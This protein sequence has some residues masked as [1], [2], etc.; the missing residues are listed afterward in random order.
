MGDKKVA[1]IGAGVAHK[2]LI[3]MFADAGAQVTLCDRRSLEEL[4]AGADDYMASGVRLSLGENYLDGLIGQDMILRTPGFSYHHPELQA[5]GSGNVKITSEIEL[6]LE[7]CRCKTIGV[8]G[9]DGKTTTSTLIASMLKKAGHTVYLGGNIGRAMLPLVDTISE[10]DIAVVELS[11]FQLISMS[12]SPDVAV[13]TNLTPNHLDHHKTMEEYTDAKRNI[14]RFQ[15]P[16]DMAVLGYDNEGSRTFNEDVQGELRWFSSEAPV[17][18]GACLNAS[19]QLCLAKDGELTPVVHQDELALLGAHNVENML[20]A[21]A[22]LRDDIDPAVMAAVATTFKGVEHRIELVRTLGGVAWY[23]DSI[24]TSPTRVVA[25]LRS[26]DEDIILIAGGA[27]KNI[28]YEPMVPEILAKVKQLI[29]TGPAAPAIEKAVKENEG[30]AASGLQILRAQDLAQAVQMAHKSATANDV[31]L[32]S[33][34]CASFDAYADFEE[35]GNHF[36]ALVNA[37]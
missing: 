5:V 21:F 6:F 1:F 14:L 31:V 11:S 19:G 22:A 3:L 30:F 34:A 15:K 13:V 27:D 2:E 23:N 18:S 32:L 7:Y 9:S 24:A 16:D 25:G 17:E 29:L 8:T 12:V 36:K 33:P 20:A 4:G 35:R 37:L 28:P 26:F 10:D